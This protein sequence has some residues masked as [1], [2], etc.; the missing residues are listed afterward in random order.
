MKSLQQ[1]RI[2]ALCESLKLPAM[3]VQYGAIAE[4]ARNSGEARFL[5]G[6]EDAR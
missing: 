6:G 4:I 2:G 3:A 1:E 5:P